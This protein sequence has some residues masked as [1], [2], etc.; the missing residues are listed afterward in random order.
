MKYL[1]Y[2]KTYLSLPALLLLFLSVS[3]TA[4][5]V[6]NKVKTTFSKKFPTAK[7]VEWGKESEDEY[8]AEFEMGSVSYSA[9]FNVDGAWM[10][11]EKDITMNDLPDAVLVTLARDFWGSD[12]VE[13][14]LVTNSEGNLYEVAI[15]KEN[16][17]GY[18][19]ENENEDREDYE[20]NDRE[21]E[22]ERGEEMDE[23]EGDEHGVIDLIFT[24]SGKLVKKAD[25]G[26]EEEDE[27]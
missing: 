15:R 20:A 11:T 17:E 21:E 4:Q 18:G 25:S 9:N 27:D 13:I 3:C 10:E 1:S 6:P 26:S 5:S 12:I 8:E 14:A 19:E 24:E 22:H 16:D 7:S 2:P 23:E